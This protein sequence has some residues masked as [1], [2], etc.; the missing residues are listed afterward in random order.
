MEAIIFCGIQASGKST[1]FKEYFFKTH[2]RISLDLL[3]TRHKENIFLQ[4]CFAARQRF[5]VDNTNATKKHRLKYIEKAKTYGF[6]VIGYYFHTSVDDAIARNKNRNGKEYIPVVGIKSTYKKFQSPVY[7]E[8]FDDLY[9]VEIVHN[10][11]IV[12]AIE[13]KIPAG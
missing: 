7:D 13:H 12:K 5:V 6:R 8:D 4:T 9:Q 10:N 1:F 2:I 3:G 11:F